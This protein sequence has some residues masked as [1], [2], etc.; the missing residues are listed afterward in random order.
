[1]PLPC[2]RARVRCRRRGAT[3]STS[4]SGS[5]I[6]RRRPISSRQLSKRCA[7]ASTAT[8]RRRG[9]RPLREAVAGDLGARYGVEVSPERV[10]I[11]P[12]GKVTM[13]AA[14][15]MFGEPGVDILYPDPG[16]PIYRSM[17]EFTGARPIPVPIREE[18]GFGFS[19]EEMLSLLTLQDA[20]C[21]PELPGQSLWR[22]HAPRGGRPAGG[23]AGGASGDR[24]ALGRDL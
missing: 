12:G 21:D 20:A 23:G 1:M 3:S 19:A 2:W 8:R 18:N 7:T 9:F 24:G 15:L 4:G 14:I 13:F 10:L 5:R 17:I 22:G 11:V 6:F 16:F